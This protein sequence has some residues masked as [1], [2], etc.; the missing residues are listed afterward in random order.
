MNGEETGP[1]GVGAGRW[2]LGAVGL[3]LTGIGGRQLAGVAAAED[4]GVWLVGALVLHDALIAPLVLAVGFLIAAVPARGPLRGA[5]IVSGSLVLITLPLLVRPGAPPHPS[6]L[7]LPYGRNLLLV[8]GAVAVCAALVAVVSRHR[9]QP[10]GTEADAAGLGPGPEPEPESEPEPEPGPGPGS[11]PE[12]GSG[13]QARG[14]G[15]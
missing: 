12:P 8:I 13:P 15:A 1:R 2:V 10:R 7:P 14:D 4:V 3:L 11:G 5:L 9:R 6:A